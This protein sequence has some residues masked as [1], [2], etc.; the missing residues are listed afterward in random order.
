[1]KRENNELLIKVLDILK[2]DYGVSNAEVARTLGLD[3]VRINKMKKGS[4]PTTKVIVESIISNYPQLKEYLKEEPE[5]EKISPKPDKYTKALEDIIRLERENKDLVV[6]N[7]KD[8]L[9]MARLRARIK[10]LEKK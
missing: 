5:T 9:E 10:E 2:K 6:Q 7:A 4:L 3:R 1:M 8:Q